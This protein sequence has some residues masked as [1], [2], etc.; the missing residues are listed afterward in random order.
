MFN[1]RVASEIEKKTAL[2]SL[3]SKRYAMPRHMH[4]VCTSY[5]FLESGVILF[6]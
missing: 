2:L 3:K 6:V 4:L 1:K 5:A